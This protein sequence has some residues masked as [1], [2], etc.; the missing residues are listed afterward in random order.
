MYYDYWYNIPKCYVLQ[1][2]CQMAA[3]NMDKGLFGVLNDDSC[4]LQFFQK[5][6]YIWNK[7]SDLC[8]ELYGGENVSKPKN[9]HKDIPHL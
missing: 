8:T 7:I 6:Q 9:L 4:T 3:L 5:S 2:T 1:V